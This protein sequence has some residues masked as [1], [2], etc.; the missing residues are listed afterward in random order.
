MRVPE[1][2]ETKGHIP[3]ETLPVREPTE[4]EEDIALVHAD[5]NN[6]SA[7]ERKNAQEEPVEPF[8]MEEVTQLIRM[9]KIH[10]PVLAEYWGDDADDDLIAN[11]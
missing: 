7:N 8:T 4:E 3:V 6:T 1:N 2:S 11:P 9:D 5:G 10:D